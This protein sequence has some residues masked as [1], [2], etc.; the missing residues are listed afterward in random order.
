MILKVYPGVLIALLLGLI[1]LGLGLLQERV[2]LNPAKSDASLLSKTNASLRQNPPGVEKLPTSTPVASP[3]DEPEIPLIAAR[4]G[5]LRVTNQT[6]YPLRLALLT[7]Q[8]PTTSYGEPAHWDFA[9]GEGGS[10]GVT[11]SLPGGDLQLKKGD[12]LV[13]F[14]QDG[15]RRY[16]GPY[17]V[18]ET[19]LPV[20]NAQVSEWQLV[21]QS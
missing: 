4:Q 10:Q 19:P 3:T 8:P 17:V 13:A 20:W 7:Y 14:A 11:L 18:G 6:E 1:G 15:S 5:P 9:P 2:E 12:I 16:W 21:L